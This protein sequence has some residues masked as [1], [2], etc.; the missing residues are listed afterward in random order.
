MLGFIKKKEYSH[1]FIIWLV[2]FLWYLVFVDQFF[3]TPRIKL[4]NFI[5]EQSFW[6]LNQPPKEAEEITIVV[7]DEASRRKLNLKWPWERNITAKLIRDIVS[8][9]PKVIGLDIVFSGRS[10]E[11]KDEALIA[12]FKSHPK[13][14]LGYVGAENYEEK[15][16]KDFVDAAS[17]IGFV[18]K[19]KT[20]GV[21]NETKTFYVYKN[22]KIALSLEMEILLYYLG[23]NKKG[24]T[25]TKNGIFLNNAR[26]I[27]SRQG[28]LPLNYLVHPNNFRTIPAYSIFEKKVNP[29]D[30]KDKIVLIG[31]TDP[32]IHDEYPTPMGWWPGVTIIGNSLTMLLSKRFLYSASAAQNFLL[33]FLLGLM[34]IFINRKFEFLRNFIITLVVLVLIY[35]SMVY[36][37]A[38]DFHFSYLSIL[39]SGATAYIVPNLYRYLSLLYL[40]NRLRNLA[41][42]DPLTGLYSPRFFLL[43]FDEKLKS[44]E[45]LVFVGIRIG[46]YKQLTLRLDFEQIKMLSRLFGEYL[47]TQVKEHFNA[48]I[49][50][51]ISNDTLAIS[52]EGARREEIEEFFRA[53]FEKAA[54]L[55][56]EVKEEKIRMSLKGCLIEKSKAKMARSDDVIYQMEKM[57][58]RT[59]EDQLLVEELE[60]RVGEDGEKHHKDI[61]DFIAYDW[62]ERSRDLERSL[63][64]ILETNKRLDQLNW[65]ALTALARAIDAKSEWTAGHSE[66]VTKMALKIGE[67]LGLTREE[68]DD[69][70]RAGL[71]H[72]IG[73][74]GTPAELIDKESRLT[75]EEYEIVREHPAIGERILEP[76]KAYAEIVP[77]VRQHHEKFNGKGYPDGIAGEAITLGARIL[78]VADVYDALSSKRPYRD[79]MELD[80]VLRIIEKDSGSHFDPVV[81]DALL[82]V[83]RNEGEFQKD[84]PSDELP[85]P[86]QVASK[87]K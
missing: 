37:R 24:I 43:Q 20:G 26:L 17:S 44:K 54:D 50:S 53:F 27:P 21:V 25:V 33:A 60:E 73:K 4:D 84:L 61:L 71:L 68:L 49:F 48:S 52:I 46:N 86:Q 18:N 9:S 85:R 66:R 83:I 81:V 29:L 28:L 2:L 64:E 34:I 79:A 59:R 47:Q 72:D 74:I 78:A 6:F 5:T 38:R 56:W 42:I 19:P 51:R 15:P 8:F 58:E 22:K 40:G 13:V 69:L 11:E 62:E 32:L 57:F 10:E 82:E 45:G 65:G 80:Q 63:Q 75:D 35:L 87:S 3:P 14:V 70:H 23:L 31:V 77:M 55:E 76:I 12:A 30:L 41:I 1:P 16:L 67:V 7:I 39:F 36:L